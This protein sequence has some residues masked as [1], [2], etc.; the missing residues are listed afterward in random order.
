MPRQVEPAPLPGCGAERKAQHSVEQRA[1]AYST[2]LWSVLPL[3]I[4]SSVSLAS[5]QDPKAFLVLSS[6]IF[7]QFPSPQTPCFA[8]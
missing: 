2:K 4:Q 3:I 7:K 5:C 1:R 8:L 6:H